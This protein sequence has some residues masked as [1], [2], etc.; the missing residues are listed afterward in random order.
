M[1]INFLFKSFLFVFIVAFPFAQKSLAQEKFGYIAGQVTEK[2]SG[3]PVADAVVS[4]EGVAETRA[5]E[6]GNYRLSVSAGTYN[7]RFR[8]A[9]FAEI[10]SAQITVTAS[11]TFVQN[12]QLSIVLSEETVEI[13]SGSFE[14]SIDQPISQ[15]AL[16]RDEIRNTP[17][18]GGDLLRAVNSLPSVTAA[19]AEFADLIVRGGAVGENLT[20]IDNIPVDDF[21]A[22]TDQ[23]DNGRGGRISIFAPDVISR[24]EFSAGGFGVRYGDKMSSALDVQLRESA[25]TR[26]QGAFFVD[27][28]G[29]GASFDVPLGKKGGWL[30]SIRRSYLDVAFEI[31]K[32]GDFGTPRNWDLVNKITYDFS[33]RHKLSLTALNSFE[34]FTL[35]REQAFEIPRRLDR[36]ET[37]RTGQ[38][39]ILG[40]TLSS[41]IADSTLSQFTLWANQRHSDGGF[42][43]LDFARTLQRARDLRELQI[44]AKEELTATISRRWQIGA[45]GG[46]IFN[47]G[48]FFT[49]EETGRFFSP[50]EEEFLAPARSNRLR[51]NRT[52]SA[53]GYAQ[54]IWRPTA[55]FAVTPGVRLDR[56]GVSRQTQFSPRLSASYNLARNTTLRFAAGIYRQPATFFTL[57]LAPQNRFL[58][59]Q[60]AAHFIGGI[61][62]LA[63]EDL[64]VRVEVFRKVYSNLIVQPNRGMPVFQNT[65]EGAANGVEIAAQKSLGGRF[66][67]EIAYSFV[68]SR[69]RFTA[70]GASFPADGERPHQLTI[71][72]I[73]RIFDF[74]LAAKWRVAS[75]LPATR[76][77]PVRI[78]NSPLFLQRIARESDINALRLPSYKNLDFRV[79][80]KFDFRRW[81]IAP[82]LDI[83]NVTGADND[84][85]LS[86]EFDTRQPIRLSEGKPLPI[87]GLRIEF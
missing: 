78:L 83:F 74:N 44:G 6:N 71:I 12:A 21:T 43:R 30:T 29:A 22:L 36:L 56:Y 48:D 62:W 19:S 57:A 84:T 16:N 55:K 53:Y 8:A 9:G 14:T 45:G 32:I 40:A 17:G 24:A 20:F 47:Q 26:F 77:T 28:G 18:T 85:E 27:S 58:Q 79:E 73:T 87:F 52:A 38:R 34:T 11:R 67:G 72:G 68:H 66:A 4:I 86:Y 46:L 13:R 1:K 37:R 50:L 23:Y 25:R 10:L 59:T 39:A 82:Y 61:E 81:S 65:G 49:Y 60:R 64:R 33:P 2:L 69:R 76:R 54:L 35:S 70:Q 15:T 80:R 51:L 5:D 41:T 3:K 31:A 7:L 75:G 42:Y 63:L